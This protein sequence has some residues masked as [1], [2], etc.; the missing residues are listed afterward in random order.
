MYAQI[1]KYDAI[2]GG[3]TAEQIC[4]EIDQTGVALF[5]KIPGFIDYYVLKLNDGGLLTV[6]LYEAE[7]GVEAAKKVSADWN[8]TKS[9]GGLPE[10]PDHAFEGQV[11]IHHPARKATAVA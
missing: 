11:R 9:A 6:T 2:R 5:E 4:K 7:A 1:R 10:K 8:K 3:R